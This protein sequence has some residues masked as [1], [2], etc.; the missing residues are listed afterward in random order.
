MRKMGE[1]FSYELGVITVMDQCVRHLS[2]SVTVSDCSYCHG[3][4]S[5]SSIGSV[6]RF[7]SQVR[8]DFFVSVP[9]APDEDPCAADEWQDCSAGS[10]GGHHSQ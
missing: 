6:Q 9:L 7:P 4:G 3:S 2:C 8:S 1:F 5:C 10:H